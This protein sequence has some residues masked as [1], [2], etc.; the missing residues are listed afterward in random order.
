MDTAGA[1]ASSSG[2]AARRAGHLTEEVVIAL[3][4]VGATLAVVFATRVYHF[5]RLKQR[6]RRLTATGLGALPFFHDRSVPPGHRQVVYRALADARDTH[7]YIDPHTLTCKLACPD[8]APRR[9]AITSS[10]V[11]TPAPVGPAVPTSSSTPSSS[12]STPSSSSTSS[13]A[14]TLSLTRSLSSA[15]ELD[16]CTSKT[17]ATTTTT[18]TTTTAGG[19][20]GQQGVVLPPGMLGWSFPLPELREAELPEWP[21]YKTT[22]YRMSE[23]LE[24]CA[25]L[26][27]STCVRPAW[28]PVRQF[29]LLST[30]SAANVAAAEQF[31]RIYEE[32]RFSAREYT[33]DAAR[34]AVAAMAAF[35]QAEFPREAAIVLG[36]T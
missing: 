19:G 14:A 36:A 17:V 13:S 6:S 27:D 34:A 15:I 7:T 35:L 23:R 26:R 10:I 1:S 28:M 5:G 8:L 30:R 12:S 4:A 2:S 18:T 22:I 24:R 25:R 32:A 3:I 21:H 33:P 16:E 31:A 29:V 9:G 11:R 20:P